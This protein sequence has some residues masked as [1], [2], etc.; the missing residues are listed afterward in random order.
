MTWVH[1]KGAPQATQKPTDSLTQA[2]ERYRMSK[3]G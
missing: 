3:Q 1:I 2:C